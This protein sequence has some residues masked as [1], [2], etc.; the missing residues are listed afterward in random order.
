MKQLKIPVEVVYN[1]RLLLMSLMIMM[2]GM[3]ESVKKN[4]EHVILNYPS[5]TEN[6]PL[7]NSGKFVDRK[8]A[9]SLASLPISKLLS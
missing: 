9:S 4:L 8:V 5:G 2:N 6:N 3:S 7:E 1:L